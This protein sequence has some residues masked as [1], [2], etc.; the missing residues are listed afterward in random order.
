M[1]PSNGRAGRGDPRAQMPQMEAS[2]RPRPRPGDCGRSLM[3]GPGDQVLSVQTVE[4]GD[5]VQCRIKVMGADGMVRVM[6][7]TP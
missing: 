1:L 6:M 4:F 2:V 3:V 5:R 7:V